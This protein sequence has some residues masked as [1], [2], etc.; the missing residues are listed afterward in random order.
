VY[1]RQNVACRTNWRKIN[2][3]I[4]EPENYTSDLKIMCNVVFEH[5]R[6]VYTLKTLCFITTFDSLNGLNGYSFYLTEINR[7]LVDNLWRLRTT[8]CGLQ[9][10]DCRLWIADCGRK[11]PDCGL[12]LQIADWGLRTA[13]CRQGQKCRL[14]TTDPLNIL[15]YFHYL[16][17]I[18]NGMVDYWC[19]S[20]LCTKVCV[21]CRTVQCNVLH[22]M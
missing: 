11:T 16:V 17:L 20:K 6:Y 8:D 21:G 15:C 3:L 1:Q 12:G 10:V 22:A 4:Q 5:L 13:D 9:T 7:Y 14:R 18:V 19:S 2:S